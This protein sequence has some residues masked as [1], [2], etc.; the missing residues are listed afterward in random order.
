L[1]TAFSREKYVRFVVESALN[2]TFSKSKYEV[3]LTKNFDT[4]LDGEWA[5]RG[6]RL[7]RYEGKGMGPRVVDALEKWRGRIIAFLDD[8]DYWSPLKLERLASVWR[9][10]VVYYHNRIYQV[11]QRG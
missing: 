9:E 6:V 1:I 2:Q 4:S 10:D 3:V 7:V 5:S 8:D 11:S